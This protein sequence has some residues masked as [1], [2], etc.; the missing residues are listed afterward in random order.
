MRDAVSQCIDTLGQLP[1]VVVNNAAGNFVCP[2]ERLSANAWRSVI[3]IVLMGTINVTM[4]VGKRLIAAGY[5][6]HSSYIKTQPFYG[7]FPGPPG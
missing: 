7:P 2:S 1:P 4:D 5:S 6:K 3:D